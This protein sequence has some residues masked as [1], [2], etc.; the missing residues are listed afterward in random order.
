MSTGLRIGTPVGT[1]T[2][3][4]AT[5]ESG[6]TTSGLTA[7]W[8]AVSGVNGYY[9]DVATDIGFTTFV[10]GY[11]NLFIG[12]ALTKVVTGLSSGQAYYYRVRSSNGY[13]VSTS[14]NVISTATLYGYTLT[15]TGSGAGVS[16]MELLVSNTTVITLSGTARFYSDAACTLDESSIW[17]VTAGAR[18][19]RY[20][21]CPSGTSNLLFS[22]INYIIEWGTQ[23]SYYGWVSG[24][25]AALLSGS[26]FLLT[27]VLK[28]NIY[29]N[30][31]LS[32]NVNTLPS[33][34]TFFS[35]DGSNTINGSIAD[36]PT[37]IEYLYLGGNNILSG[38]IRNIP[39]TLI[40][41]YCAGFNTL[42][43]N[44]SNLPATLTSFYVVGNNTINGALADLKEGLLSFSI[45]SS[46]IT[47][48]LAD[49]PS[50]LVELVIH[51]VN[52][53]SGDISYLNAGMTILDLA[54]GTLN[55]TGN[56]SDL[57]SAM[58]RFM[59]NGTGVSVTGDLSSL[60]STIQRFSVT[61]VNTIIGNLS[62]IPASCTYFWVLG[63]NTI[64]GS[65]N[66]LPAGM[67]IFNLGGNTTVSG[68][69]AGKT[70]SSAMNTF[71]FIPSTGSGLS[72]TEVDNL[73]IDFAASDWNTYGSGAGMIDCTGINAARSSASDAAVV[74]L[75]AKNVGVTT[76]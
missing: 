65:L 62:S 26:D 40:Q 71:T 46:G 8:N 37:N 74:A 63:Y 33:N 1:I 9:L 42:S 4:V 27:N 57:P 66:S 19:K 15:S 31:T 14:S 3:P 53:I 51:G 6:V 47:G 32:F 24:D 49:L 59:I 11:E 52:T 48:S 38:N 13:Q 16:T 10:S 45:Y 72:T 2:A 54:N 69:T 60:P 39:S 25:N 64:S 34:C 67:R 20:L 5:A 68:Y 61:G 56:L 35:C 7:N 41:L 28:V 55:I 75:I 22:N 50:T 76:N 17:T 70:W 21:K 30:N 12:N 43:G 36:V 23:Y 44:I 73:L 18:R 29:G 58:E